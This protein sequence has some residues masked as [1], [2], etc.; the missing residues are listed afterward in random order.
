MPTKEQI[1]ATRVRLGETQAQFGA[2]IGI[3]QSTIH[4]WEK[5][6]VPERGPARIAAEKLLASVSYPEPDPALRQA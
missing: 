4:R 2:R 6:G 3:D 1:K 5:H